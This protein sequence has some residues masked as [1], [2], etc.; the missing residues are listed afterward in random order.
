MI[1]CCYLRCWVFSIK[2]KIFDDGKVTDKDYQQ[3]EW[4]C[5]TT[6][7][8]SSHWETETL[9]HVFWAKNHSS[10][11]SEKKQCSLRIFLSLSHPL[12]PPLPPQTQRLIAQACLNV[13]ARKR[14][15]SRRVEIRGMGEIER[16]PRASSRPPGAPPPTAALIIDWLVFCLSV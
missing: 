14:W 12:K 10:I 6:V 5:Q 7:V 11:L 2:T 4:W 9:R 8:W 16:N 1:C 3:T 15:G 13:K